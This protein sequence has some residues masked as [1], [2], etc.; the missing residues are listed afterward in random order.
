[1]YLWMVFWRNGESKTLSVHNSDEEMLKHERLWMK[2]APYQQERGNKKT[3]VDVINSGP[4]LGNV[5]LS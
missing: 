4:S 2:K 5:L 1:M 3:T